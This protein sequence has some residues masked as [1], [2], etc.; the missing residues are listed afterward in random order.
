M[1][2]PHMVYL[3]CDQVFSDFVTGIFQA[4]KFPHKVDRSWSFGQTY[5]VFP[6][7]GSTREEANELCTIDFWENLPWTEDG[8][9]L[10]A[11][12]WARFRPYETML[13]TKPMEHDDSFTGK[14]RWVRREIPELHKRMVPTWVEKAEFAYDFNCLLIDDSQDNVESFVTSGGAAIL[15]PKPWNQNDYIFYEGK[16]VSYV[17]EQMDKWI[18]LV[19]HPAKYRKGTVVCKK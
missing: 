15:V 14:A 5:D 8:K 10:L 17:V 6:L 4:L 1:I 16:T 13:L 9:E 19:G 11:E 18:D 3:D 7:A 12:I 2:R